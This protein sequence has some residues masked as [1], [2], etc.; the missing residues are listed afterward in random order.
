MAESPGVRESRARIQQVIENAVEPLTVDMIVE[1]TGL[2]ANTVRGHLDVL[3][4]GEVIA[5]QVAESPGRGRPRWLYRPATPKA[6]P[7]QFLAQALT[8]QLARADGVDVADEAAERWSK[9]LPH[10]PVAD[11]PDEAVAET[12]D[13]LNR[14]GFHATA[15]PVGDQI[16]VTEC[17]YAALV[18]DNPVICDIHTALII[19][20]LDQTGQPV[21]LDAMDVWARRGMCVARLNR[22]DIAPTR[23]ITLS[24]AT[25]TATTEGRAS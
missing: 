17:P 19:R 24:N 1:A 7:F 10:L 11:S 12:A 16:A 3:L 20:L 9:A 18:E 22:P 25:H 4:A 8:A 2:H 21:T 14:L 5:R 6:S 23:V 15:S 13:A